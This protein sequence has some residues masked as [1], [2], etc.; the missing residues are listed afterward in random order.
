[1]PDPVH[2]L[3][4][5]VLTIGA[6]YGLALTGDYAVQAHGLLEKVG[7]GATLEVATE[8]PTPMDRIATAISEGLTARGWLVMTEAATTPL[9]ARLVI[10]DPTTAEAR[11]LDLVKEPFWHPPV[12][13]PLGP[14]LSLE[15]VIGTKVRSLADRITARDLIAVHATADHWTHPEREELA[16]RHTQ[17]TSSTFDLA[18]LQ[19]RLEATQYLDDREFARHALD[20]QAI[21]TLRAWAQTWADDI[22][23]RLLE[24]EAMNPPTEEDP[25]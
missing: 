12:D 7:R 23:E 13:T 15:D 10:T 6:P 2:H 19:S 1:M 20:E 14:A 22:A 21:L 3:L 24:E 4:T 17:D 8:H 18:D 11:T 16:R 9:S 5:E 25:W